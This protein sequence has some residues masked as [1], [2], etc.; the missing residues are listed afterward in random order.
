[1][2]AAAAVTSP[3]PLRKRTISAQGIASTSASAASIST[4]QSRPESVPRV[5]CL[6]R[7][8]STAGK[9]WPREMGPIPLT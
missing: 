9:R 7:A 3:P 4:G 1:M 8:S 6:M 5:S 2:R